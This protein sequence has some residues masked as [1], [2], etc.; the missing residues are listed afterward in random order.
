GRGGGNV[1]RRRGVWPWHVQGNYRLY[2][3]QA[4]ADFYLPV[5]P[6]GEPGYGGR[7]RTFPFGD[8]VRDIPAD[9]VRDESFDLIL[10]QERRNYEVARHEILSPAQRRLPR[11]YLEHDPPLQHPTEQ[12]HWFDDPDGVLVHV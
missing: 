3:S 4:G 2:L 10:Y 11:I 1:R 5:K 7:G 12:K 9:A 6:G 8:N